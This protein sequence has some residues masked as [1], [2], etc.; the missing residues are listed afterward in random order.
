MINLESKNAKLALSLAAIVAGMVMLAYA[1][2]PL[3][4]IFCAATG[5]G[6][7]PKQAVEASQKVL[8][9]KIT[10]RFDSNTAS[11]LGWKFV[12]EQSAIQTK[13]GE[14]T[15]AFFDV[16]NTTK[17]PIVGMATYNVTPEKAAP[18]FMKLAC[19]C[20]EP[21]KLMPGEKKKLPVSFYIDPEIVNDRNVKDV[22]A[23]TLSYTFF[24]YEG[25]DA[26][27]IDDR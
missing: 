8:D 22:T 26:G 3:Y 13:I 15:L 16:I 10:I 20:Y 6:G 24:K 18:Y 9:R 17:E 27:K 23:I 12:P 5:F 2:V 21:E 19:F 14:N 7:T 4:R 25:V 11:N 1:S